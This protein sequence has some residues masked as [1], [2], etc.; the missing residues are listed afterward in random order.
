MIAFVKTHALGNDFILVEQSSGLPSDH[1][2]L[3]RRICHRYFGIGGDGLILWTPGPD[4]FKL[5]IY[6]RDG[7][8]AECSGNG[9]RCMAAYLVESR[10]WPRDEV[11]LET[12]SGLYT[13]RRTEE[14]YEAD[15]G[16]PA[17]N[18]EAIP[19]VPPIPMERVVNFPMTVDGESVAITACSTGNPHCSLFV[20]A[21]DEAYV[22]RIGP[23]LERDPAFPNR[24]NVEFIH[25][26]NPEEIEVAFW[27]R[28]VGP[29]YAS[30]TGSCAATVASI[31]NGKTGRKVTVHTKT[32]KL[33][34]EW[35][36]DGRLKLTS[37]ANVVAE[38]NYL[39]A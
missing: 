38:G 24:T 25:V 12:V 28:G 18:P 21:P 37:T 8:E 7:S 26:L 36:E 10:R 5:R 1:P 19:F 13:L 35:P 2:E 15:M 33:V 34:V 3:A 6:N 32:G 20:D 31:A 11:R 30:G 9:L 4:A 29:T 22:E 17:L 27:E 23:L 14:Q 39:E 16:K